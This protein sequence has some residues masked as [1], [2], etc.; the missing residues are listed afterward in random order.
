MTI[1]FIYL[2]RNPICSFRLVVRT[3]RYEIASK[4]KYSP[5]AHFISNLCTIIYFIK[6]LCITISLKQN[7]CVFFVYKLQLPMLSSYLL[8]ATISL[9]I[10]CKY[11]YIIQ[12]PI[13]YTRKALALYTKHQAGKHDFVVADKE[14]TMSKMNFVSSFCNLPC[15]LLLKNVGF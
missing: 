9:M 11:L 4:M 3:N 10:N 6:T 13:L 8:F 2:F 12:I 5:P 14:N 1:H 15:M 7:V